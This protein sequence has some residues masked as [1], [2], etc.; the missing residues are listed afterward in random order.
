M[1]DERSHRDTCNNASLA[2][3][4][5]DAKRVQQSQLCVLNYLHSPRC[6]R[7]T[8][9]Y[10]NLCMR[11]PLLRRSYVCDCVCK[12]RTL[13]GIMAVISTNPC[14]TKLDTK[15]LQVLYRGF[16]CMDYGPFSC[17]KM[18]TTTIKVHIIRY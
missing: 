11:C 7:N 16:G 6:C 14:V 12:L 9:L 4:Y 18:T 5:G 2:R 13:I 3:H 1:V 17:E 8:C 10:I 15:V